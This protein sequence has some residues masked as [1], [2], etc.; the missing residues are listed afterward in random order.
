[1]TDVHI[2]NHTHWDREWFLT[3][4]YTTAWV[5]PLIDSLEKLADAN[6]DYDYLFD[7]QTLAIED[8][9]K[10]KP[11]YKDRVRQLISGGQLEIGPCYS[12]PD[13]RLVS[14]ELHLRN[15]TYGLDD[16]EALGGGPDVAWLVDTFGHIS[17]APQ[18]LTLAGLSGVFVWRGVP[19]MVP[20]FKWRGSDGTE[21]PA[22]N[23]FGGYRNLY[24]ITKTPDIAVDRLVAETEKLA[25]SYGSM[26]VPLFDGYDLDSDPEDPATYY[27]DLDVPEHVQVHA[28]S[29]GRYAAA[30][31]EQFG[32]APTI[33]GELL[34]GKFGSTFPGSLSS[35]AYLKVL[36]HDAE[37][38]IHRRVEPLTVL[39]GLMGDLVA[40]PALE[41]ANRTLLQNG[42]HDCLCGVS[43]DQV[44]ERMDRSY[45]SILA[46]ADDRSAELMS[47]ILSAFSPGTYA[48]STHPMA[49]TSVVRFGDTAVEASTA[50]VGVSAVATAAPVQTVNRKTE[51]FEWANSHFN[52]HIDHNGILVEGIGRLARLD[53]RRDHG[54][55]YSSEPGELIGELAQVGGP[56]VV[57][58]SDLDTTV[59]TT[60]RLTD[61]DIDI[62]ATVEV[63]FDHG[64]LLDFTIRLDSN[65]TGFRVDAA[66]ETAIAGP[67]VFAS[68]PFDVVERLHDDT[69]LLGHNV[70]PGLAAIL[71]GQRETGDVTEFPFHDFV[72]MS[73]GQQTRA[74]L[75]K[76]LR[77]YRSQA[78]GTIS[79]SLRR[80]V[81]WLALTGLKLRS[82]DAGPAMYV[83]GARSE[84][85]IEHR[86]GFAVLSD[87]IDHS[88][89]WA[90][91]EA[92]QNPP[93]IGRVSESDSSG[94]TEWT[95][96]EVDLPLTAL[97]V[98]DDAPVARL[99][100]PNQSTTQLATTLLSRGLRTS[101]TERCSQ[102]GAKQILSVVVDSTAGPTPS[103]TAVVETAPPPRVRVGPSRSR[104][105]NCELDGLTERIE[106]LTS[107]LSDNEQLLAAAT[108]DDR[109]R[110][111]HR[112][113]VL[114]RERLELMLSLELN[115]R[116]AR[117]ESDVSIPDDPDPAIVE[118]GTRLNDLRIKRRIFDYVV[119]ALD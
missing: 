118:L 50:G 84:R 39:A 46:M 88:G 80:S 54:D 108:G 95:V 86:I 74:V 38:A 45:R 76:G 26:P 2:I 65:G 27:A 1:M 105:E 23:L 14:G 22:I 37:N 6:P 115:Q 28:S 70:D 78:D 112:S 42:V 94:P 20:L 24:G 8:L 93:M 36:H 101:E 92:F 72:A 17:Q 114:D 103:D 62:T 32:S 59:Q 73:S 64:P 81:E 16:A 3:H 55:T 67:S 104:P 79:V 12:Q 106:R 58:E 97:T 48:V 52:A 5:S 4:E 9:L 60:W 87:S 25:D 113:Y 57:D 56:I 43:I 99:Y 40:D 49:T 96:F 71:M 66:F 47:T 89:L 61:A 33:E 102:V 109:Y 21:L 19:K 44:H 34:S 107:E 15:L 51:R 10:L 100:N 7:G 35:R 119:A 98:I 63:R 83:P 85:W 90:V 116:L 111:L 77:S 53:V 11:E 75:G 30:A 31:M 82:G 41:E 18:M 110:N 68:M 29:P 117:S 69:D 13:W 91:N